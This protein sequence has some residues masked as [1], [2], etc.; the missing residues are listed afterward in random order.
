LK[1]GSTPAKQISC[2]V[3]L[4]RLYAKQRRSISNSYA[5]PPT[6]GH[7]CEQLPQ[8]QQ[9]E[10]PMTDIMLENLK[11]IVLFLLFGSIIGLSHLSAEN[12]TKIKSVLKGLKR[13]AVGQRVKA[14]G[15]A[16]R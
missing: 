13:Q 15:A 14:V 6:C 11:L 5:A 7:G 1:I 16:G 2:R 4:Y 9:G 8:E 3:S 10:T 12:L